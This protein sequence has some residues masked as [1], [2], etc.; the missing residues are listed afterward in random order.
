MG[1]QHRPARPSPRRRSQLMVD[2]H[3]QRKWDKAASAFDLMSGMGAERRW[4]PHKQKLFGNMQGKVLFLALGTGLDIAAFPPGQD[5]TAIDIS[6]EMIKRAR[7]RMDDY[8]GSITAEVMD[9]HELRFEDGQFDQIYTSCTFCSVPRPVAGLTA[10]K[11]VLKPGGELFMFEH[12]GS[13]YFP[14][15][16]SMK[17]MSIITE[18]LG[19]SMDR[20]TVDNVKQAGFH[21]VEVEH[22]FLD[23]VKIIKARKDS[24]NVVDM[25]ESISNTHSALT[26]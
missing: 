21:I 14:L 11:R 26:T 10:L 13:K 6:P 16:L 23:V 17:F 15:N 19:P 5:I 22:V 1:C 18:K 2:L 20:H 24:N 4:L 12:T 7:A 25:T 8:S 3:T 9:V